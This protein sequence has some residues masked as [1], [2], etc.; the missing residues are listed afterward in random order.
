MNCFRHPDEESVVECKG[1]GKPLC[2]GCSEQLFGN[3]KQVCSSECAET[4]LLNPDPKDQDSRADRIFNAMFLPVLVVVLGGVGGG[5]LWTWVAMIQID[6]LKETNPAHYSPYHRV[7]PCAVSSTYS[8]NGES[9][10]GVSILHRRRGGHR[11][12]GDVYQARVQRIE[13]FQKSC[14]RPGEVGCSL[15]LSHESERRLAAGLRRVPRMSVHTKPRRSL[16]TR[17]WPQG[18]SHFGGRG[19]PLGKKAHGRLLLPAT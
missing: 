12:R 6:R 5:L 8:T 3:V 10:T 4:V 17:S 7:K 15:S 18:A 2:W 1:C 11:R 13:H 9:R 14:R 16:Q 19:S